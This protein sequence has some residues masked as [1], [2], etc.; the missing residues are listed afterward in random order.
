M[1]ISMKIYKKGEDILIGACD[2][3]LLG[4]RLRE[5]KLRLHVKKTFYGGRLVDEKTFEKYLKEA[6]I[7]NLVGERTVNCAKR[8]GYVNPECILYIQGIPHAQVVKMI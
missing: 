7:A 8:L 1:K 3:E 4:K 5:G 6:T 2:E